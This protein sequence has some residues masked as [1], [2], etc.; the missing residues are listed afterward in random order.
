[1]SIFHPFKLEAKK[2]VSHNLFK[3]SFI[4]EFVLISVK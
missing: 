3:P 1:M 2:E 4:K